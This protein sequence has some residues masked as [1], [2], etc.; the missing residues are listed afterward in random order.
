MG[1]VRAI[2][3]VEAT[4]LEEAAT[5]IAGEQS[6]GTWTEV[7]HTTEEIQR[8]YG[9]TVES[10]DR[11]KNIVEISF[12]V[13]DFSLEMGGISN[14]LT[15]VAGNLF[16]LEKIHNVRLLDVEFPKEIVT[17]FPGPN[18]GI[19]GVRKFIGTTAHRRPHV[20]TIVKPKIGLGPKDH[21]R[22]AYEAAAGGLDLIK[23]DETLANQAFNPL[24]ERVA[25]TMEMLDRA[26]EETG[27]NALYCVNVTSDDILESAQLAL[28]NGCNCFMMDVITNGFP[29][30]SSLA[31]EFK[32]PIHV[33]RTMHAAMTRNQRH[34]IHMLVLARLVR[35]AG[36][37]QLHVGCA[38]GKMEAE[39]IHRMHTAL[40]GD[41]HGLKTVF[42]VCSGG[43]HPGLVEEN[44][45]K[46]GTDIIIQAGGGV[47][48]H[49]DGTRAGAKAMMQAVEAFMKGVSSEEYAKEHPELARAFERWGRE[50][51][52][53][54]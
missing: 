50:M 17:F 37:D 20:G 8:K 26:K 45:K 15:I 9:A 24:E 10:V 25:L 11:E 54:Y 44:L 42:P 30:L 16:G 36:G 1:D 48:G 43:V 3:Y 5:A 13:E 14:I 33:H 52:Y 7:S 12:P 19:E 22:V 40:K 41:W 18:F 51:D 29:A 34:G 38:A 2:Y 4:D 47:H 6:V 39:G 27:K 49:P 23:D 53:R 46:L 21:A 32:L 35:L 31:R 28:D